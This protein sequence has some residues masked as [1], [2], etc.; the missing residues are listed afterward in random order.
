MS[1]DEFTNNQCK[2]CGKFFDNSFEL[3]DHVLDD[4]EE[5]DPYYAMPSGYKLL[6]GSLLRF[7]YGNADDPEQIK[8]ITQSTY[9]TLF[10]AENGYDLIDELVEDMVIK[11]ALKDFDLSLKKLLEEEANNEGEE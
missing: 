4:D 10:A 3:I 8:H 11:S 7:L 1:E 2:D 6:L 5:F 9:V